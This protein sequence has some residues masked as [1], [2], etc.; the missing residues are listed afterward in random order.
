MIYWDY[1]KFLAILLLDLYLNNEN[2]FSEIHGKFYRFT[3][4]CGSF[5]LRLKKLSRKKNN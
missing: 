1:S 5:F 2:R 4:Y 3:Q